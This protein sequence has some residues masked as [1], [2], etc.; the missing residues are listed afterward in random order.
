MKYGN[1]AKTH[2]KQGNYKGGNGIYLP[3]GP[4]FWIGNDRSDGLLPKMIERANQ[5][6]NAIERDLRAR[7]KPVDDADLRSAYQEYMYS[8]IQAYLE[9][10]IAKDI[11]EKN[12]IKDVRLMAI[13]ACKENIDRGGAE[14][15]KYLHTRIRGDNNNDDAVVGAMEAR[16]ISVKG[17]TVLTDRLPPVLSFIEHV[18]PEEFEKDMLKLY[19]EQNMEFK[20]EAGQPVFEP[21][22]DKFP[23]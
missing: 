8:M 1:R 10:H 13:R 18:K 20:D 15:A 16:A 22:Y 23:T 6:F 19:R 9:M 21:A 11:A 12:E 7:G 14:N 4:E 2:D 5:H 17:R 3:F